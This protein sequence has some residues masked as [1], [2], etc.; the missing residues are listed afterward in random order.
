MNDFRPSFS[1]ASVPGSAWDRTGEEA[2]PHDQQ[3]EPAIHEVPRQS[4]GTRIVHGV[5]YRGEVIRA[6]ERRATAEFSTQQHNI[7]SQESIEYAL[8]LYAS[9]APSR[10]RGSPGLRLFRTA[11][12]RSMPSTLDPEEG[13]PRCA[14]VSR[15]RTSFDRRSPELPSILPLRETFG[16][17]LRRGRETCAERRSASYSSKVDGIG[18][19]PVG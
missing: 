12:C 5:S 8:N 9:A 19:A 2:P 18:L 6:C 7:Y 13:Q 1:D 17:R 10:Q 3:A 4:R 14:R 11:G 15:P 16:R